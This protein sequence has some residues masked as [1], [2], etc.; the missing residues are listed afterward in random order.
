MAGEF[1]LFG[2]IEKGEFPLEHLFYILT[3]QTLYIDRY[4]VFRDDP[5]IQKLI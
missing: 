1:D 2:V 4:L 5:E 3:L